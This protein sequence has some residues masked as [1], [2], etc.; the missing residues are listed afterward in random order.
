LLSAGIENAVRREPVRFVALDT[1]H[2]RIETEL[3][4]HHLAVLG[5]RYIEARR[6][7]DYCR[8]RW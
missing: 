8:A 1:Q 3:N 4:G 5:A 7:T 6:R 2:A